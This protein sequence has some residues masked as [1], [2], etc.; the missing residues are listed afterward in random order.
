M[1]SKSKW[2]PQEDDRFR[3]MVKAN[4]GLDQIAAK[5]NRTVR[6]IRRRAYTI[7]LPLKWFRLKAKGK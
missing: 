6:A 5:L 3:A 7:G 4:I 2:S 1:E